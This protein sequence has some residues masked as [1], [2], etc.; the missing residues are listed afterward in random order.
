LIHIVLD[1]NIYRNNPGRNN[2]NF[3]AIEK[4][5]NAGWLKLHVPYVVERE[6]QTQ[7]REIYSRDLEK[8]A[9]WTIWAIKKTVVT[10]YAR[11]NKF[12]KS[13]TLC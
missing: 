8:I 6:F 4:L 13:P 3:Q 7:Q 9:I 5:A 2:L 11:E 1:T 10:R 12:I